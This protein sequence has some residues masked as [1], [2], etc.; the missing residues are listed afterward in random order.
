M[1]GPIGSW[2]RD[3]LEDQ[4]QRLYD[5]FL[6]LKKHALKQ[7]ERIKK[8]ATKLLRLAK[9]RKSNANPDFLE[10][11]YVAK[12]AELEKRNNTLTQKLQLA[13]V[14]LSGQKQR[15]GSAPNA[16]RSFSNRNIRTIGSSP[17]DSNI[18]E[19]SVV[20]ALQTVKMQNAALE[21]VVKR[22]SEQSREQERE[23]STLKEELLLKERTYGRELQDLTQQ[24]TCKQR[25]TIQ[26]NLDL[27][28]VQRELHEKKQKI[29][30]LE[31]QLRGS[32][33]ELKATKVANRQLLLEV[34]R[35]AREIVELERKNYELKSET[36]AIS[37]Q[38]LKI[39]QLQISLE[40]IGRENTV[41]KEANE[42][43]LKSVYTGEQEQKRNRQEQDL[44]RKIIQLESE[45]Q[46]L[47]QANYRKPTVDSHTQT[48][49][50]MTTIS[51]LD[52]TNRK[53]STPG[54][55]VS[56][57]NLDTVT[58]ATGFT[59]KELDEA[60][61]LLR[62]RKMRSNKQAVE[63]E[64]TSYQTKDQGA[65]GAVQRLKEA[66]LAHAETI[67]ELDKTRKLLGVQ[68]KINRN[69]QTQLMDLSERL[70]Q[71]KQESV[72]H[73]EDNAKLLDIRAALVRKLDALVH[74]K[75]L[76]TEDSTEEIRGET[77]KQ[78]TA[79]KE[80][81][82][83][84]D[85]NIIEI[86]IGQLQLYSSVVKKLRDFKTVWMNGSR[87]VKLF[88]TWD[89]Y[90]FDTHTTAVLTGPEVDFDLT[91]EYPVHMSH[92]LLEYLDKNECV[93]E[94]HQAVGR[95]YR[96]LATGRLDMASILR[97]QS[98]NE[99]LTEIGETARWYNAQVDL[100]GTV[101]SGPL[102]N[103][104]DLAGTLIGHLNYGIRLRVPM[105]KLISVYKEHCANLMSPVRSSDLLP[106]Q[107]RQKTQVENETNQIDITIKVVTGLK[108][109]E[110]GRLPSPYFV[111]QFY[112][113][114]EYVSRVLDRTGTARFDERASFLVKQTHQLSEYLRSQS[115]RIFVLDRGD[116]DA[117]ASCLGFATIPLLG[118]LK[119]K[120]QIVQGAFELQPL[121]RA[122]SGKGTKPSGK[123]HLK[124]SW[125]RRCKLADEEETLN[126]EKKNEVAEKEG[127][128]CEALVPKLEAILEGS[129]TEDPSTENNMEE[130]RSELPET[131]TS[132]L[133]RLDEVAD[134]FVR[135]ADENIE[136]IET[137]TDPGE[138]G[139]VSEV[140]IT[141][142]DRSAD[143]P[144][145]TGQLQ[146]VPGDTF[147]RHSKILAEVADIF[148][149]LASDD[150]QLS[151]GK[152]EVE[153]ESEEAAGRKSSTKEGDSHATVTSD[154]PSKG[155][156]GLGEMDASIEEP[157]TK[158]K[159]SVS[160]FAAVK[161]DAPKPAPRHR[162]TARANVPP[163][164]SEADPSELSQI[165]SIS[166]EDV[167]SATALSD[168]ETDEVKI[169]IHHLDLDQGIIEETLQ[170][171]CV[172]YEFLDNTEST[173]TSLL[174]KGVISED[175]KQNW[176]ATFDYAKAFQVDADSHPE[177]RKRLRRLI[178]PE[179]IE[180]D[181]V[182]FK[183]V[184]KSA[185]VDTTSIGSSV[186][187]LRSIL[188]AGEDMKQAFL[189][190]KLMNHA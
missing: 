150:I 118:L 44:S 59:Q 72:K 33:E 40:D 145:Q 13:Q 66:E 178:L 121:N 156:N 179:S 49:E 10:E 169:Q 91:V 21:E 181:E 73:L 42:R 146:S 165:S 28:R 133:S 45:L 48:E 148:R 175:G 137:L 25:D 100:V 141:T 132:R 111:F 78:D 4:Y 24:L 152:S 131:T 94:L 54:V 61:M 57:A 38:Q 68:H 74:E 97:T 82:E 60:V 186:L 31:S 116:P 117:N 43:L 34:E 27:I 63:R 120:K 159:E 127:P 128:S 5:D 36:G 67:A 23:I 52:K 174:P 130:R 110:P 176:T 151:T 58:Q 85:E 106:D 177:Q 69:L 140:P 135:L 95:K 93:I 79:I 7:E 8:M 11:E 6:T 20:G 65:N 41:L 92:S 163:T 90:E 9:D 158:D 22:L 109:R 96:T 184:A 105:P 15:I 147:P 166:T 136:P 99:P 123:I 64:F 138:S 154:Q 167:Q 14:Q 29:I 143:Q 115:L 77:A 83:N 51:E 80:V 155:T 88:L 26:E 170:R 153:D 17:R 114:P 53:S 134:I 86:H 183:I 142:D 46:R 187:K 12:V 71:A 62:E 87:Q 104:A 162:S 98:V 157:S 107:D 126:Q 124:L 149:Q 122:T 180:N 112:D 161:T 164:K 189:P 32:E 172:N 185:S 47:S 2:S 190:G 3:T 125:A 37:S 81:S 182:K 102:P 30:A 84:P 55:Q 76:G 108:S 70:E 113:Q 103:P 101:S 1:E 144:T 16:A 89:F 129:K 56:Q 173:E 75:V 168:L 50:K 19:K 160:G 188:A 119:H 35:H 171:V 139:G 18:N 39:Q